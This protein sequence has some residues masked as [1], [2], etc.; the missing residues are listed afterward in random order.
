MAVK[1]INYN[2]NDFEINY[3]ILNPTNL[4]KTIVFLHGWGSNKEV[5]KSGFATILKDFRHI[6]IDMPGFGKSP[7]EVVLT[8][9]DY[10][11][12][13]KLFLES[14]GINTT[15]IT[16]AGHSFGGK[17]ATLLSPKN[18][19]LLS[20]AGIIEEKSAKVKT[21]IKLTKI[22]NKLG[23]SLFSKLFRS[24][25]VSQ[26]SECMYGTFKNVVDEDF[27]YEFKKYNGNCLIFWGMS[28][29]ATSLVSGE[30]IHHIIKNSQFFPLTGDHYF[31]LK[32]SDKIDKIIKEMVK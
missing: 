21:K 7:N 4:E 20:T 15:N 5:M 14:L 29:T 3:E 28:D 17:V 30:I 6:Y 18:L 22:A 12:I 27:T 32:N 13:M 2:N 8:T 16:I 24:K 11:L 19:I 23:L 10:S 9:K 25:D 26:M 31:F 1:K